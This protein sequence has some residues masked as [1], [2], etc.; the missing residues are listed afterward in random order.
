[1]VK[2]FMEMHRENKER[3]RK[4]NAELKEKTLS[5]RKD[6]HVA[7]PWNQE[8]YSAE[9]EPKDPKRPGSGSLG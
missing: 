3:N 5:L 4:T 6:I 9:E 1:M 2:D 8:G 7:K